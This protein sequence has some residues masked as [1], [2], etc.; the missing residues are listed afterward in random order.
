MLALDTNT[1]IYFFKGIGNV[2]ERLLA[3]AP[4]EIAIPAIVLY[5][6]EAGLAKSKSPIKR[7]TQLDD[8]LRLIQVL[9][10]DR[11]AAEESARIRTELEN[12]STPIGPIDTL[13]AGIIRS[14]AFRPT[15]SLST[16]RSARYRLT[17]QDSIPGRW[18]GST[19]AA[20]SGCRI[21]CAFKAQ[22]SQTRASAGESYLG[23][24]VR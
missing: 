11:S 13:I 16:L 5:E 1:L 4:S 23:N 10:F 8:M 9:P 15:A 12:L 2:A 6:L 7:R 18:L 3:T 22:P 19:R 20:I 17:R 21:S 24:R 14:L